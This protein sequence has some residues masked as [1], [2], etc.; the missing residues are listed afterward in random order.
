MTIENFH[1]GERILIS[2]EPI[3]YPNK[4]TEIE[5]VEVST[6]AIKVKYLSGHI[7]WHKEAEFK[8]WELFESLPPESGAQDG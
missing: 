5:I 1:K 4:I 6:L 2:T 3:C 8:Y 7:Q